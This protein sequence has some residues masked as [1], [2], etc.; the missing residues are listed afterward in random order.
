MSDFRTEISS[1]VATITLDRAP[2]NVL[3]L[4]FIEALSEE[5]GTLSGQPLTA[6]VFQS[7]LPVFSAGVDVEDHVPSKVEQMLASF[8]LLLDR[9][10]DLPFP[11]IAIVQG[12]ALGGGCEF[13]SACDFVLASEEA[14]FALPEIR[15]GVYPP[16]AIA[17]FG[18]TL[19]A[20]RARQMILTGDPVS[21]GE[22]VR[23]G[24]INDVLPSDR[25]EDGLHSL[26]STLSRLSRSSL[27]EA[28]K[29]LR[30]VE[31]SSGGNI[32]RRVEEMYRNDL[33]RTEDA[34][35]GLTAFLEKRAPAWS[36]R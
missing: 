12:G 25:I 34:Q 14:V 33:M 36:H 15:L 6:V 16:F 17:T 20:R 32:L 21:A 23:L 5:L 2:V 31:D 13:I 7:A 9:I 26:L 27:A 30:V 11:S 35:E 3:H 4:P 18:Q 10:R 29:A 1:G 28:R 19:G 8:H 24:L 22:A